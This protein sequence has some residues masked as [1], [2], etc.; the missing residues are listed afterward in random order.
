MIGAGPSTRMDIAT[1][2]RQLGDWQLDRLIAQLQEQIRA[3]E[4]ELDTRRRDDTRSLRI[5]LLERQHA[6][7][8]AAERWS[9]DLDV[10]TELLALRVRHQKGT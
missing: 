1:R 6:A 2:L 5:A 4:H 3:V 10:Y 8:F 7:L 9:E